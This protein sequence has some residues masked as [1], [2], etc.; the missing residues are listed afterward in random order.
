MDLKK[1]ELV[2]SLSKLGTYKLYALCLYK[3]YSLQKKLNKYQENC[4]HGHG[5]VSQLLAVG[6]SVFWKMSASPGASVSEVGD[7]TLSIDVPGGILI[8][9]SPFYC[10]LLYSIL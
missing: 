10:L 9:E 2:Y 5:P 4:I 1:N 7:F 6:E 3:G 8:P